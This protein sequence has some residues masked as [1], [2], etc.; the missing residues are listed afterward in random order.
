[1]TSRREHPTNSTGALPARSVNRSTPR[2]A[3]CAPEAE[4]G[5][6]CD[7]PYLD[8]LFTY[9]LSVM[10]EHEA[11]IAAVGEAL[12]LAGRQRSRGRAPAAPEAHRPWL[13]ALARWACSRRL[14]EQ[15][16]RERAVVAEGRGPHG[17]LRSGG[18]RPG[19]ATET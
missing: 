7:E 9:C 14:V 16:A 10:C 2:E 6:R 8:G 19:P 15:K 17:R 1:M 4:G 18:T 12:A 13:Y 11:A 5:A 3:E